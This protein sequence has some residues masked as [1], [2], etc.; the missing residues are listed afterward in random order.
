[1]NDFPCF[2]NEKKSHLC[3]ENG[4]NMD[5]NSKVLWIISCPLRTK[6]KVI[7]FKKMEETWIEKAKYDE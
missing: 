7:Y 3:Q 2:Q 5:W 6:K 1:M 4:R